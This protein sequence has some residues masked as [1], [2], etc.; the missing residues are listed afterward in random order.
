[1]ENRDALTGLLSLEGFKK[2]AME[3]F[4]QHPERKYAIWYSDIQRFK[5]IND[6]FGYES[7]DRL[8]SHWAGLLQGSSREGEIHGRIS[9]DNLISLTYYDSLGEL[10]KRFHELLPKV[11]NYL[12]Q[13][14]WQSSVEIVTGIYLVKE[15]D[16]IKPDIN[17]MID[18]A[19]V[20]QKDVKNLSGSRMSI[21][22]ERLWKSQLRELEIRRH[23]REA[24][25]SGEVSI[26]LQPQYDFSDY[27]LVGAEVLGR[28]NHPTLGWI[29]PGEFIPILERS[30]QITEFDRFIWREACK[31]M[32]KWLD[33]GADS[34]K[35]S[36]SVN[37]SRRDI[38]QI[39]LCEEFCS[40]LREYDLPTNMLRIEITESAYM[41]EPEHLIYIVENLQKQ[42]FIVEMDDFGSGFSSLNMLKD[43]PVDILKVDMRFL[44]GNNNTFRGGRILSSIVQMADWLEMSVIAE[45]VETKEQAEFLK[46][47]GCYVMQGYY[48]AKPRPISEFEELFEIQSVGGVK[49]DVP[50]RELFRMEEFLDSDGKN[51]YIFN[52]CIGGAALL[53]FNRSDVRALM[54]NESFFKTMGIGTGDLEQYRSRLLDLV[55]DEHKLQILHAA[56]ECLTKE[57]VSLEVQIKGYEKWI[58]WSM[59]CVSSLDNRYILFVMVED[60]TEQH[61]LRSQLNDMTSAFHSYV[62]ILPGGVI[63][64]R[65][66]EKTTMDYISPGVLR[67]LGYTEQ[68][69]RDKYN[70]EASNMI[71]WK[72]RAHVLEMIEKSA[73][74][75]SIGYSE[76][77]IEKSDGTLKWVATT[78]RKVRDYEGNS[79]HYAILTDI[80]SKKE[81]EK[82]QK[83]SQTLY[84]LVTELPRMVTYD[85]DPV[86]DVMN[87]R[88]SVPS[89]G[90]RSSEWPDFLKSLCENERLA[91]EFVDLVKKIC[92]DAMENP[93][94]GT[95]TFR[96]DHYGLGYRWSRVHYSSLADETGKVYRLVGLAT[97]IE[98]EMQKENDLLRRAQLDSMTGLLNHDASRAKIEEALAKDG[99]GI[100]MVVDVD[101]FKTINDTLGHKLGDEY[102]KTAATV[103][104]GLFR[105]DDIVGRYGGDEFIIFLPGVS[106]KSVAE[107]QAKQIV[108]SMSAVQMP[109]DMAIQCSVGVAISAEKDMTMNELFG[110]AERM[111]YEAKQSGKG[112]HILYKN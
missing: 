112:K 78:G 21:F 51:A 16:I 83:R 47:L 107:R 90:I 101:N 111:L 25:A 77:R 43:V 62:D 45:G 6:A 50:D 76:F 88:V 102:L 87:A 93:M 34:R 94:R 95:F 66:D 106:K 22:D 97:D 14:G 61:V 63:R 36:L 46:S 75:N 71:Y 27:K 2:R 19:H 79:W 59:R 53:E 55:E 58:H 28:W 57:S 64:Y 29:S 85:Y 108:N 96:S 44:Q 109:G 9:G 56:E 65:T 104:Q 54:V 13:P 15:E 18:W 69:L 4:E 70:N 103:I 5:Y 73:Q 99:T 74:T 72:D 42:G 91:P 40:L 32:R 82:E 49:K 41:E 68:E 24:L 98:D 60:I 81:S 3:L 30:G 12:V 23:V 10:D 100:L 31:C 84:Q 89:E 11:E 8:L 67:M 92:A 80:D 105:K 39:D 37:V 35:L 7:G 17:Q 26:W 33:M 52:S 38:Y 20:A 86:T 48:F 110:Q 1:M